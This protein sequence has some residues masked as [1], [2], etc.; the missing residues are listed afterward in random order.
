MD[1]TCRMQLFMFWL[2]RR[3]FFVGLGPYSGA[4]GLRCPLVW[5]SV[6]TTNLRVRARYLNSSGTNCHNPAHLFFLKRAHKSKSCSVPVSV[7]SAD[8]SPI[9]QAKRVTGRPTCSSTLID[10]YVSDKRLLQRENHSG[11]ERRNN[12]ANHDLLWRWRPG[13]NEMKLCCVG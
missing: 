5:I 1:L 9:T 6:S 2:I 12:T 7:D 8:T 4:F 13:G 10:D 11:A 3:E